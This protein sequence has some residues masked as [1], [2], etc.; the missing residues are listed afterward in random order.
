MIDHDLDRAAGVMLGLAA[1]DA[2]GAGY[3]FGP[4]LPDEVTP[5]MRGGGPFG[6]A[7]GEWTD[8]TSMAVPILRAAALGAPPRQNL[9]GSSPI[10]ANFGEKSEALD[11]IAAAWVAWA[12]TAPDVG[13]QT[14]AVLA[15]AVEP[16]ATAL[17]EAA[18]ALHRRTGRTAG[19]G[20]LMRAAPLALAHL[21]DP[22]DLASAAR[23][24]S[25]LTH[26]DPD[27]GDACV[28]WS[29]AIRHAVLH[30]AFELRAGLGRL[31]AD[32][33]D[34]WS[35]RI[36]AAETEPISAFPKNGWVVHAFQAAWAAIT[37]TA[38]P[39]GR[40]G[41]HL[42]RA[43]EAAVR[44]GGDTDTV[45]AIAGG[46]LGARWG[47]SAVPGI[48]LRQLHGWPGL[49]AAT[50]PAWPSS[51]CAARMRRVG[52][53]RSA[54]R[55]ASTSWLDTRTTTACGSAPSPRWTT[56]RPRST[57]WCRC[58]GSARGRPRCPW[59]RCAWSTVRAPRRTRTSTWCSR[60]RRS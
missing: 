21:D 36:D 32:R 28:L 57:W 49:R 10:P 29:L 37:Q 39:A 3:E 58:A 14:R 11:A 25:E 31:P 8:D 60:T 42:R 54:R 15:A 22:D 12:R 13:A 48:W 20:S 18:R 26:A 53:A 40:P 9:Q 5:T 43:L 7:P 4:A 16:T 33:R 6:W 52:R 44:A 34:L 38:V 23:A 56:C 46:L 30:G 41:L 27:A 59:W 50:S 45:A 51:P 17:T 35:A 2:L 24:L 47:G 55:R 1:G 19:N